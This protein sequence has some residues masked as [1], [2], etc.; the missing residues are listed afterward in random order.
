M[1]GKDIT[2]ALCDVSPE[3]QTMLDNYGLT[4]AIGKDKIFATAR[5]LTDAYKAAATPSTTPTPPASSGPE[6]APEPTG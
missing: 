4:D 2:F 3:L 6:V 1:K 5:D